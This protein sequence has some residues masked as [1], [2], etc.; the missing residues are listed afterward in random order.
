MWFLHAFGIGFALTLGVEV[1]LGLCMA[2]KHVRRGK[3]K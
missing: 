1:A 3:K 2:L